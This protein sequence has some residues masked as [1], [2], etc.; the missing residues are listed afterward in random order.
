VTEANIQYT[1]DPS[2]MRF[3]HGM[4]RDALRDPD[5]VLGRVRPGDAE[6][7]AQ[8]ASYYA[9]VLDFLHSHHQAEDVLLWPK[10]RERAPRHADLY[11]RMEAQHSGLSA[12]CDAA[13]EATGGYAADPS[14]ETARDL[15]ASIHHLGTEMEV[16]FSEEEREILPIAA[17]TVSQEEWGEMPGYGMSH[18]TAGK[19]WLVLG[20]VLEQMNDEERAVTLAHVPPPA[21]EMWETSG[22]SMFTSLIAGIRGTVPG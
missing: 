4:L 6:Q 14:E 21:L 15:A 7:A 10:L 2:D 16:H 22:S 8:V 19:P 9:N 13:Q 18:L 5:A 17:V 20:L 1:C 12:A 11:D 3:P